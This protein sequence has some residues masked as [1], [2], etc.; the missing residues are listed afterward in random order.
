MT[1]FTAFSSRNQRGNPEG[2]TGRVKLLPLYDRLGVSVS[3]LIGPGPQVRR[4][5]VAYHNSFGPVG[6]ECSGRCTADSLV[7]IASG[8]DS[9]FTLEPGGGS[10]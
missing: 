8:D 3:Y 9:N 6:S 4:G 5:Q 1:P 2:R 10:C 7:R